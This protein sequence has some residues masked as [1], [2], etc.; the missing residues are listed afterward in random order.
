MSSPFPY[1]AAIIAT[2]TAVAS[3]PTG[4]ARLGLNPID[5]ARA[6]WLTILCRLRV[7]PSDEQESPRAPGA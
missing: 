6:L 7:R 1:A 5:A 2:C 4:G 3:K